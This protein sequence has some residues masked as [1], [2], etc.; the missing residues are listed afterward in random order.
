LNGILLNTVIEDKDAFVRESI[1][2]AQ[3]KL[4]K[5]LN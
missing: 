1:D 5:F 3:D 2:W 4:A